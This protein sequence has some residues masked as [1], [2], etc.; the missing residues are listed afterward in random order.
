MNFRRRLRADEPDINLIPLIDVLLVMLI[1]LAASTTFAHF[2]RLAIRLPSAGAAQAEEAGAPL[3]LT[4]AA[5]GR[6]ALRGRVL[7]YADASQLAQA[8]RQAAGGTEEL[9]IDADAAAAHQS[10]ML[11][12]EAAGRAGISRVGFTVQS[13]PDAAPARAA[14]RP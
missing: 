13:A 12:L 4:I 1:F 14:P 5:D 7:P 8:L 3:V 9:V 6:Y 11:A 2:G 10:V